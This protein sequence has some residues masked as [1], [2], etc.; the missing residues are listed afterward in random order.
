MQ[1]NKER[2][3]RME[4]EEIVVKLAEQDKEIGS[5]KHRMNDVEEQNKTIQNLAISV[6]E[7]AINMQNMLREQQNISNR[8]TELENKPAKR[9]EAVITALIGAVV[10][11]LVKMYI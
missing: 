10:G 7:L 3:I 9:W 11:A 5:L 1:K 2:S 4:H 6:K 8:L